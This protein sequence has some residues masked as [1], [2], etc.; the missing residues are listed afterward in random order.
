MVLD[1]RVR[2]LQSQ[3]KVTPAAYPC[4]CEVELLTQKSADLAPKSSANQ[5]TGKV[6]LVLRSMMSLVLPTFAVIRLASHWV[7]RLRWIGLDPGPRQTAIGGPGYV[8]SEKL[9]N[10]SEISRPPHTLHIGRVS[11]AFADAS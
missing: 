7:R 6:C 4:L 2:R 11:R 3:S 1:G 5:R 9:V 8:K 10:T